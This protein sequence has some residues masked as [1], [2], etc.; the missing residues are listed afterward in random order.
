RTLA[1]SATGRFS[2][3]IDTRHPADHTHVEPFQESAS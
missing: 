2:D 3:N 1:A